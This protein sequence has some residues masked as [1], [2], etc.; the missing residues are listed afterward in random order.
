MVLRRL[1]AGAVEFCEGAGLRHGSQQPDRLHQAG[2]P[3]ALGGGPVREELQPALP[4]RL[5]QTLEGSG[6]ISCFR[7]TI[8]NI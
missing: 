3:P 6:Q 4:L 2:L 1:A 8:Y 7:E 5:P